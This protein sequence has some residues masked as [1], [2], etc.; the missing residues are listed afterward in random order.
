[1]AQGL[2]R[3]RLETHRP[4]EETTAR[5]ATDVETLYACPL[6]GGSTGTSA[7][8]YVHLQTSHRKSALAGL[9]LDLSDCTVRH[10]PTG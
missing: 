6:C 9:V 3:N 10:R 5:D 1:M 8:L 7:D 4:P 2:P